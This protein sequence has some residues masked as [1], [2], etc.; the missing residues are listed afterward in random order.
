MFGFCAHAFWASNRKSRVVLLSVCGRPNCVFIEAEG[1][2]ALVLPAEDVDMFICVL[3]QML[4][5][6]KK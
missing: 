1:V 4:L 6:K 2:N 5:I 3:L